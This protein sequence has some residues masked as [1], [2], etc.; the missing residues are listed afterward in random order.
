[1]GCGGGER[2]ESGRTYVFC[3][4][5]FVLGDCIT[6]VPCKAKGSSKFCYLFLPGENE[7]ELIYFLNC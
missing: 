6:F 1:M 3:A 4:G 2:G 7:S 5:L